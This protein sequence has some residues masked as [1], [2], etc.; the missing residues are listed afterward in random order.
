MIYW[1]LEPGAE[2]DI[3]IPLL[4]PLSE[5]EVQDGVIYFNIRN[6]VGRWKIDASGWDWYYSPGWIRI[7]VTLPDDF[8]PA[9][10]PPSG[11]YTYEAR[12]EVAAPDYPEDY[13]NRKLSE[14]ICIFGAYSEPR[15]RRYEQEV[16]YNQYGETI[17]D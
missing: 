12:M 8:D 5:K 2:Y 14:G 15:P 11:E 4:S 6:N 16:I 9:N 13:T 10:W 3:A 1:P 7:P 17:L